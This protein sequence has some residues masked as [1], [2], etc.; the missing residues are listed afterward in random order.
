[1]LLEDVKDSSDKRCKQYQILSVRFTAVTQVPMVFYFC[2]R[3]APTLSA[4]PKNTM[5]EIYDQLQKNQSLTAD[6]QSWL[7]YL[8]VIRTNYT[9][10]E[11]TYSNSPF[12]ERNRTLC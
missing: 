11:I 1:M 8:T 6:L 4:Y 3:P 7:R 2:P 12:G 9:K 5:L 10:L